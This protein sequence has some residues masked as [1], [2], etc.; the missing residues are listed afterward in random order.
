M[1]KGAADPALT[2]TLGKKAKATGAAAADPEP[3]AGV[4]DY[5]KA[6]TMSLGNT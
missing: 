5:G 1:A 3:S 6:V 4:A 2:V